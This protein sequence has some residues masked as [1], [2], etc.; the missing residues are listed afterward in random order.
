MSLRDERPSR[1]QESRE[2]TP[3]RADDSEEFDFDSMFG[4]G[5]SL[6][7]PSAR[8]GYVQRWVRASYGLNNDPEKVGQQMAKGWRPRASSTC[9][10]DGR[11]FSHY[12]QSDDGTI[13]VRGMILMERPVKLHNKHKEWARNK[14]AALE[15]RVQTDLRDS[16]YTEGGMKPYVQEDMARVTVKNTRPVAVADD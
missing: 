14:T 12:A 11:E 13:K 1:N 7:A 15:A 6:V 16:S 5:Q 10:N 3:T 9:K 2:H 8:D 4:P